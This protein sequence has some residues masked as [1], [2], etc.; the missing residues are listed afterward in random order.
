MLRIG[1]KGFTLIEIMFAVV[2]L[3]FGL[4]LVLRSFATA[5][6]GIKRTENIKVASYLLEEKMEGI[7]EGV[8]EE[9][10]IARG[11]SSGELGNADYT[12]YRWS[13]N[14]MPSAVD[15]DLNEVKLEILWIEGKNQRSLF[16]TTYLEDKE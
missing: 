15:E 16:A 5:L 6:D 11:E 4:V 8:K 1:S 10:G 7:K 14:V 3:S 12:D 13:L 2:I 9:N